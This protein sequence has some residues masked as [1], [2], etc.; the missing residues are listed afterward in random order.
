MSCVEKCCEC[1]LPLKGKL[2]C[3]KLLD[4]PSLYEY[5]VAISFRRFLD[6]SLESKVETSGSLSD[7][8]FVDAFALLLTI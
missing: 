6:V 2:F 1:D 7:I 8:S 3:L 5:P 4:I